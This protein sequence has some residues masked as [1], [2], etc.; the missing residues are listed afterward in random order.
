MYRGTPSQAQSC[1]QAV[2]LSLA[3]CFTGLFAS[4]P[5]YIIFYYCGQAGIRQPINCISLL[6]ICEYSFSPQKQQVKRQAH[7]FG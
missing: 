4:L 7:E 2:T 5:D 1:T 3:K 6:S